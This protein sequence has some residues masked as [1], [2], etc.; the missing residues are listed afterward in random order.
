MGCKNM[1]DLKELDSYGEDFK[2]MKP[3]LVKAETIVAGES[4]VKEAGVEFLPMMPNETKKQYGFRL[5]VAKFTNVYRDIVETLSAKPFEEETKLVDG[6]KEKSAI[7]ENLLEFVENVDGDGNNLTVFAATTFFNGVN[8]AI[9]WIMIDYPNS[10]ESVRTREE[11]KK[12]ALRPFWS[13]VLAK[14]IMKARGNFKNGE[15]KLEYIKIFEPKNGDTP[16][17]IREFETNETGFVDWRVC[18]KDDQTGEWLPVDEGM[19]TIDVIPIVPFIT[20]R[21]DGKRFYFLPP[22]Q[23]ALNLQCVL[24]RQESALEYAKTMTAFPMLSASGVS[25]VKDEAGAALPVT[26]GPQTVLYAPRNGDG[27]VGNWSYVEPSAQSLKFLSDDV[28]E[29]KQDLRELGKQPLTAQVGLTV[30]TTAYAAGKSK[31]AVRAWGLGMKDVLENALVITCKWLGIDPSEYDPEVSIYD[32]YD[33]FSAE[34]FE[35]VRAMRD[36]G[37]LS[38]QTL[39]TEAGRRGILSAEFDADAEAKRILKE[40]PGDGD[41]EFET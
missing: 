25:P 6:E 40:M 41:R 4:A 20:G 2:A 34:D 5:S 30:I 15:S 13:I 10:P 26:V 29:T 37:D 21:R 17:Q 33:D 32:D 35:Q 12:L 23:D 39:W 19:L 24:Y 22:L 28:K 1:D 11:Q 3:Y 27:Q 38:R 7:P 18:Q 36:G 31:T 14:N 9:T 16:D 8:D